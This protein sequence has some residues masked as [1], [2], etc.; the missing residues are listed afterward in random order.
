MIDVIGSSLLGLLWQIFGYSPSKLEPLQL[1]SWQD[2]AIFR[3]PVTQ[4]DPMVNSIINKYLRTLEQKNINPQAQGFWLQSDWQELASHQG[5]TPVSAASLTKIA[6]TLAVLGKLGA[7]Y[8]FVT[9]V[10]HTGEIQEGILQGDLIVAGNGDPFFVWEEAI[11]IANTLNQLGIREI[12][13]NL[14]VNEKFYMNYESDLQ[15]AG[16]L[17][18]Q[19]LDVSLWSSEVTRQFQALP[20][21]T[22]RPQLTIKGKTLLNQEISANAKLILIHESLPLAEILKQMNIYSNNKMAQMLADEV[23]GA[24]EV[25]RY[26]AAKTGVPTE[27]IQL[28]NGSGLGVEN[29]ISPRAASRMLLAIDILLKPFNL[30]VLDIFPVAGRDNTGTMKKRNIPSGTTVKTGT[31]NQVSALAGFIPLDEERRVWFAIINN[32]WPIEYF[33]QQQDKLLQQLTQHWNYQGE[34]FIPESET[35]VYLGDPARNIIQ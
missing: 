20:I 5:T 23:G 17:L 2:T 24:S 32:G 34:E 18:Q 30:K 8:Q 19:G 31:L 11:S 9:R 16:K 3:L 12:R 33:R 10:Y 28:I 22:P 6:T 14:I 15:K 1:V 4:V 29:R 7:D 35:Q 25:A 26:A 27:E 13:G 21:T